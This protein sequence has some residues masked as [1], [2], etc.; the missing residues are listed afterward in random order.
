MFAASCRR[1]EVVERT[2][3]AGADD[4]PNLPHRPRAARPAAGA[5]R[6]DVSIV[7]RRHFESPV[8]HP[9]AGDEAGHGGGDA[10]MLRDVFAPGAAPD[11][12][13]RAADHRAGVAAVSTGIAANASFASGAPVCVA[14]LL[15]RRRRR[16]P[17][18]AT[19]L[20]AGGAAAAVLVALVGVSCRT[21]LGSALYLHGRALHRVLQTNT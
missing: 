12:L 9:I 11:P 1:Y 16:A 5:A 13:G 20:L 2:V 17:A 14:T 10:R 18:P 6:E 3:V 21:R 19:L 4:D 7:V 15:Q 8:S